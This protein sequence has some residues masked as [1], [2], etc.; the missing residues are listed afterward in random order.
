MESEKTPAGP[1]PAR[2][3][4]TDHGHAHAE[5]FCLMW[6]VCRGCGHRERLWNSRDGVTPFGMGCPS[7]NGNQL[8]HAD[9]HLDE[10]APKHQLNQCQRFWRDGTPDEA[11]AIMRRRINLGRKSGLACD[12]AKELSLIAKARNPPPG[13]YGEFQKGWPSLGIHNVFDA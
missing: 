11:E 5:A 4:R 9:W 13:D 2:P 8:L 7:C 3:R 10:Y 1:D 6:Y 12:A